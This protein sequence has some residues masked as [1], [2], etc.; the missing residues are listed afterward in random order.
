MTV[1]G[2][3]KVLVNIGAQDRVSQL[4]IQTIFEE[5][6]VNGAIETQKML[7]IL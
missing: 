3:R 4:D 1:E 5:H 6:G 2:M 7:Q